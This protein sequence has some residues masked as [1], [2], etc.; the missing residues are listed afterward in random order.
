MTYLDRSTPAAELGGQP[1]AALPAGPPDR[2]L[3]CDLDAVLGDERVPAADVPARLRELAP[4][5]PP[6][7]GMTGVKLREILD[8]ENRIKVPATGNRYP[9]DPQVI[10]ARLAERD[11]TRAGD[12]PT[13]P[14]GAS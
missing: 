7:R 5:H 13:A 14:D 3:L 12:G 11:A 8:R 6:Y 4:D 2:D 1:P 10:R 9:I